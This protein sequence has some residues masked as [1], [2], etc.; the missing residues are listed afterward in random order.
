M[1]VKFYNMTSPTIKINKSKTLVGEAPATPDPTGPIDI[2]DPILIIDKDRVPA[3]ANYME[4]PEFGRSY[5]IVAIDWTIAN[6]ATVAGHS[7]VLSNF[8]PTGTMNFVR[9]A[10]TLT[11]MDD[12]S[13]PISDYMV[14][15]YFPMTTW[16]DIFDAGGDGRRYLLRT[17]CS[18]ADSLVY[19]DLDNGNVFW[20]SNRTIN[21]EGT[22]YYY[23]YRFDSSL[24][25]KKN[26]YEEYLR[27]DI[28]GLA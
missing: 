3:N 6:T 28:Q 19:K 12:A 4:I 18:S 17:V 24:T 11:E 5:F 7:D 21:I 20:D 16:T 10:G 27:Q 26:F 8:A 22:T 13:Y 15:E 2:V 1:N 9:G 25:G 14:E 23:C